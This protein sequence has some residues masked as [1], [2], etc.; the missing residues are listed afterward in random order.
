MLR[1]SPPTQP[2]NSGRGASKVNVRL[3]KWA[4][5][6]LFGILHVYDRLHMSLRWNTGN[7]HGEFQ[8]SIF[9]P[10]FAQ[11]TEILSNV[12]VLKKVASCT[13][14]IL[15]ISTKPTPLCSQS[16]APSSEPHVIS[17]AP[18]FAQLAYLAM[19]FIL[20]LTYSAS[21]TCQMQDK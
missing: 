4:R 18:K 20:P 17:I 14:N 7:R 19:L 2:G 15:D 3:T 5:D 12:I 10:D 16:P 1:S 11:P 8:F 13:A 6:P 9:I 21:N